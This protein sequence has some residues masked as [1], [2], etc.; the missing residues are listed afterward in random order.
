MTEH[1]LNYTDI[2]ARYGRMR[3]IGRELS[4]ILPEYVPK[5]AIEATAKRLGFWE[6]GTLVLDHV[7]QSCIL[8]DQAIHGYFRDGKNAVD[9]YIAD[10]PPAPGSDR[11]TV[12]AAMERVF[13]SL[14][15]VEGIVPDVGVHVHDLLRE[16]RCFLADVGFSQTAI[17]GVVLASRAFPF[18]SF[19]TTAGAA[20][21]TDAETLAKI[22]RIPAVNK[23]HRDFETMPREEMADLAATI[24]S[25]CLKAEGTQ[26]IYYEGVDEDAEDAEEHAAP[27]VGSPRVGRNQPCPCGSGKKYKKCCGR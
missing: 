13:Y 5:K 16:R 20:L 22:S 10:H 25:I 11:E 3:R 6:D 2:A 14:F 24:I 1:L 8:S 9:R 17:A 21:P 27:L 15:Q 19:I 18:E 12:L 7:D 26:R 23:P 4:T